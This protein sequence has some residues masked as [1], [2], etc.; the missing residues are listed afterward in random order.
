MPIKLLAIIGV[1]TAATTTGADYQKCDSACECAARIDSAINHY[2]DRHKQHAATAERLFKDTMRLVLASLTGD[3]ETK[4]GTLPA[5]AAAGPILNACYAQVQSGTAAL[6]TELP[7]LA[8]ASAKLKAMARR[9]TIKTELPLTPQTTAGYLKEAS[10]PATPTVT[11]DTAACEDQLAASKTDF[12]PHKT[13]ENEIPEL[14]EYVHSSV[15]CTADGT[16]NCFSGAANTGSAT[17]KFTHWTAE[18]HDKSQPATNYGSSQAKLEVIISAAVNITQG[19]AEQ[20]KTALNILETELGRPA[21]NAALTT[22]ASVSSQAAFRRQ[23]IRTLVGISENEADTTDPPST[24]TAKIKEKYGDSGAEY[25][26]HLWKQIDQL[27]IG[28]TKSKT[29]T[30]VDLKKERSISELTEG[31]ARRI[32]E[33]HAEAAKT[34]KNANKAVAAVSEGAEQKTGEKKDGDNKTNAT[35]CTATEA[36]KCDKTKCDWNAEKNSAKL[37]KERLLFHL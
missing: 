16:N 17:L 27:K 25:D 37:R 33:L 26:K 3:K 6:A 31:L 4:A 7:K 36:D 14:T 15:Y 10:V 28:V 35:D 22:Y 32:G 12:D 20:T 5:L 1:I 11:Q 13:A 29:K 2:T 30:E 24:L 9:A 8:N 18:K 23:A 19:V 21:C 34:P